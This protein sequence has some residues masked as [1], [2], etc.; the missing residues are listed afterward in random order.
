M[1][2]TNQAK[3]Q[4]LFNESEKRKAKL[5]LEKSIRHFE[6]KEKT[7][8]VVSDVADTVKRGV[9]KITSVLHKKNND[10]EEHNE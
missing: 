10:K 8:Q 2:T 9:G 6:G 7:K 5:L 3:S 1:H 4:R